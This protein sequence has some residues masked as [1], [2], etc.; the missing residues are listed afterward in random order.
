MCKFLQ[1][2]EPRLIQRRPPSILGEIVG[3]E[4]PVGKTEKRERQ[5]QLRVRVRGSAVKRQDSVARKNRDRCG[6]DPE[7]QNRRR[8]ER[9]DDSDYNR[10]FFHFEAL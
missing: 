5:S 10:F 9:F 6:E 7:S 4:E 8:K 2:V 3:N 1:E